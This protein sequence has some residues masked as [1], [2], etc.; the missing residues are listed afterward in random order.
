MQQSVSWSQLQRW[1]LLARR[2]VLCHADLLHTTSCL[3]P[4]EEETGG[5][6]KGTKKRKAE[7]GGR[8][9]KKQRKQ[10]ASGTAALVDFGDDADDEDDEDWQ[11]IAGAMYCDCWYSQPAEGSHAAAGGVDKP[12]GLLLIQHSR[13]VAHGQRS[14]KSASALAHYSTHPAAGGWRGGG[15]GGAGRQRGRGGRTTRR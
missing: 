13:Y 6:G 9:E 7:K 2:A 15:G 5:K 3:V 11:V 14:I 10:K 4:Q 1:V 8:G 12:A